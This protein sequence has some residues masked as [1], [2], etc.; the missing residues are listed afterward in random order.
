[1]VKVELEEFNELIA[2]SCDTRYD[3][4]AVYLAENLDKTMLPRLL[5]TTSYNAKQIVRRR[6]Q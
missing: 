5:G 4:V 6:I 1:M 2:K 3:D